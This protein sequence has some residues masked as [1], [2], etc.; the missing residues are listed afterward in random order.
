M[1]A[2]QTTG[3][4]ATAISKVRLYLDEPSVRAKYSDTDILTLMEDLWPEV[5]LDIY[6]AADNPPLARYSFTPVVDQRYYNLPCTIGEILYITKRN[7]NNQIE[8]EITPRSLYHPMGPGI[9]FE[10][11][12]RLLLELPVD[13]TAALEILYIPSGNVHMH[14]STVLGTAFTSSTVVLDTTPSTGTYDRR[15]NSYVGSMI[16]VLASS[17]GTNPSGYAVFPVQERIIKEFNVATST[18]TVEPDFDV[19]FSALSDAGSN[20]LTYEIYPV[21]ATLIWPTLIRRVAYE[22]ATIENKRDRASG[23]EKLYAQAKRACAL[24]MANFQTRN[25]HSFD[26]RTVKNEDYRTGTI[27]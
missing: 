24:H 10:G 20:S 16:R 27:E 5:W 19:D 18:I 9:S 4:I 26:P 14:T 3:A 12:H 8:W 23:L 25:P 13:S 15:P 22:I 6:A 1:P 17:T 11:N 7:T 2:N 21:E